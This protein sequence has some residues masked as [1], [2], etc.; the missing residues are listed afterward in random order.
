MTQ[1]TFHEQLGDGS[2]PTGVKYG[3]GILSNSRKWHFVFENS[4]GATVTLCGKTVLFRSAPLEQGLDNH[5]DNCAV[6]RR[7]VAAWRKKNEVAS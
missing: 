5:E 7:K 4:Y 3:W 2:E 1:T 6:C